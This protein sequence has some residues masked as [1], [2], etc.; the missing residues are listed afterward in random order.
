MA[1]SDTISLRVSPDERE[2]LNQKAQQANMTLTSY[3]LSS[4]KRQTII[5]L[6]DSSEV[7]R[8]LH[9]LRLAVNSDV[10][11]ESTINFHVKTICKKLDGILEKIEEYSVENVDEDQ[12][13]NII[14]VDDSDEEF[15]SEGVTD[16]DY[17]VY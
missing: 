4:C 5:V 8:E 1:K 2:M 15:F 10:K 17:Q 3:I 7:A 9:E 14:E 6:S 12:C 13:N 16:N 11:S